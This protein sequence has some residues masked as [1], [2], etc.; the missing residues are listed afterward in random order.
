MSSQSSKSLY[1]LR[2]H[3]EEYK[4]VVSVFPESSSDVNR[5]EIVDGFLKVI[6]HFYSISKSSGK[7]L[8]LLNP[9]SEYFIHVANSFNNNIEEFGGTLHEGDLRDALT[10]IC[11]T[12]GIN[13]PSRQITH[14]DHYDVPIDKYLDKYG[15]IDYD[16]IC[17]YISE[18]K[19]QWHGKDV[20]NVFRFYEKLSDS[21]KC[22]FMAEYLKFNKAKEL[23]V[24]SFTNRIVHVSSDASKKFQRSFKFGLHQ[25]D[26]LSDWIHTTSEKVRRILLL[27]TPR[28]EEELVLHSF[29]PFLET[30][31]IESIVN[32]MLNSILGSPENGISELISKMKYSYPSILTDHNSSIAKNRIMDY[33][34]SES[35]DKLTHVLVKL[36][37][38][39]CRIEVADEK[40][41]EIKN[42]SQL[43][44]KPLDSK[45]MIKDDTGRYNAFIV[46]ANFDA[47]KSRTKMLII[48]HPFI[49]SKLETLSIGTAMHYLPLL[50]PPK[51]WVNPK[52]GGYLSSKTKFISTIDD[53]QIDLL[54]RAGVKGQLDSA[55]TCL[56]QI[57][58][59]AWIINP[60]MLHIFNE[61]MK[62]PHGF[63]SI[64]P[65]EI[66]TSLKPQEKLD[67]RN[68]RMTF[69]II[70]KVANAFG[71][72]GDILYH[73]YMLD[74]R[75]RVY[76]FSPLSH[77]GGDLTRSLF[78]FWESKPLG[79]NGF[80]WVKYQLASLF[81]NSDCENFYESNKEN[82]IDSASNPLEG[83][84]WWMK[85]DK[86]FSALS[87][88]F[89]IKK[90]LDHEKA[91]GKVEEFLSRLP[92]HQ[93]G[94]CNGLQH[95]AALAADES[96]GKAV[97]LINSET[98]QDVYSEVLK[99]V[100]LKIETDIEQNKI[101][102]DQIDLAKFYLKILNRK[103]VKR[104][105]MT[106]VY[107]VTLRG[108]SAQI[109]DTIKEVL[110]AHRTNPTKHDYDEQTLTRLESFTL[111][112]TGY[113]AKKI[114]D[115]IDE[116][117]VHAKQIE[118]WLLANTKRILTAYNVKTLDY[119][120]EKHPKL[121]ENIFTRPVSFT[122][123]SWISPSG[124]PVI[125]V[126]RKM[127]N[128]EVHTAIGS[129]V[130]VNTNLLSPM[131][132]KKHEL[133]IAPNFIHSLDA[134]HMFMTCDAAFDSGVTFSAIHDSYWTH[135]SHVEL[136]SKILREKFVEL[137]SFDY[138]EFVKRDFINQVKNSY[139]L[140]YF[141]KKEYPELAEEVMMIR[142]RSSEKRKV[143]RLALE[144]REMTEQGEDHV[145]RKLFDKYN[146][147]VYHIV[148]GNTYGY[149]TTTTTPVPKPH[150][151]IELF[152]PVQ[153]LD[154]PA[155]GKLDIQ[156]VLNSKYFFS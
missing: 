83:R 56:D 140:V 12:K 4:N 114:L 121:Y 11:S 46:S 82:I 98:K 65:L 125:Q 120:L 67:V 63:L 32:Y 128:N 54:N 29:K 39:N 95:Y 119:T 57:G 127:R 154:V 94:S 130:T 81:G 21:E 2:K 141:E 10:E 147:K 59:T 115:S 60:D 134:S 51:P 104:P 18:T 49:Q 90:I 87:V 6:L 100:K 129:T 105:V 48:P 113:L 35:Y 34:S 131:D 41:T 118:K 70:N 16:G 5:H 149:N 103:L 64:P 101:S 124:F 117:F 53:L 84:K 99:I 91:G 112:H 22:Q 122:P 30:V 24:E 27:K 74:F 62:S 143:H 126:Y 26:I 97:N 150:K 79:V 44:N 31:T 7:P 68:L 52:S 40:I 75:G 36:I 155:R 61:L 156:N 109:L 76:T 66:P 146:P 135:P 144:L 71:R 139:Q 96:G 58:K 153:I 28:S 110:E 151:M 108:A 47:R 77:Y 132:R 78:S 17:K 93:D 8:V 116:L 142:K 45:F 86:P 1:L 85:A 69:D 133:A 33:I 42:I 15:G 102:E 55:Y 145:M 136:L 13:L 9:I 72:N 138:L 19:F 73:C 43:Q 37:V 137:H 148:S 107:G 20:N 92:I 23:M 152:V 88:C 50:C 14:P 89:E 111:S 106:T 25:K 38:D 80:H 3:I 123:M